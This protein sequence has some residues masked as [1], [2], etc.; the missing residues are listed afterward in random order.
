MDISALMGYTG[1][2]YK[3]IFGTAMGM[4]V[5]LVLMMLWIAVPLISAVRIFQKKN[6]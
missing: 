5:T 1:A 4:A 6:L 3:N 2:L